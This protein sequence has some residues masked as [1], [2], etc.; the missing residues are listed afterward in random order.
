MTGEEPF[1]VDPNDAA[2]VA[3]RRDELVARV[4]E[5]AG[6][7]ARSLTRLTGSDYGCRTYETDAGEWTLKWEDGC[8]KFLRCDAARETYV[9]STQRDP[10]PEALATALADYPAFLR[11]HAEYVDSLEN[12]FDDVPDAF[13]DP[14]SMDDVIVERDRIHDRVRAVANAM[15]AALHRA[16]GSEYGSFAARVE[17]DRWELK[18]EDSR[19]TYLRVGGSDGHYL[20]SQYG[21]PDAKALSARVADLPGFVDAFNDHA[22]ELATEL[23]AVSLEQESRNT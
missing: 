18:R 10:D 7:I 15:A 14:A 12:L 21:P 9:V 3:N 22:T 23:E 8:L 4:R 1:D 2:A 16:E 5:H 20:L 17:G 6:T 19:A 11:A 13:P